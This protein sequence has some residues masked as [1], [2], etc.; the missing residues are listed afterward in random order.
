MDPLSSDPRTA[1]IAGEK[2][3]RRQ[4]TKAADRLFAELRQDEKAAWV[5]LSA[6]MS[7][8]LAVLTDRKLVA[9][10]IIADRPAQV[11]DAPFT[12]R[13]G[14]KRLMG[15]SVDVVGAQGVTVSLL[16]APPDLERIQHAAS[17]PPAAAQ[18]EPHPS[19][20]ARHAPTPPGSVGAWNWGR[21][22]A[23]WQDAEQMAADH[24]TYLG[25]SG[26]IVT[27]GTGDGGL[28]AVADGA[29]AQVK[30]HATPSG[31]PDIQRLF[32]AAAGFTNRLFYATA[33]TPAGL[34]EA[35]R[36]DIALFQFAVEGLV[37]PI[38]ARARSIA[39]TTPA[40]EE[41]G[42]FGTLTFESRQNRAVRW[43]QQIEEATTIPISNRQ[44]K[45][46]RQIAQRQQALQLMLQ[47]LDE[48]KDSDNPLY[49]ARRKERTLAQ[50]EKTLKDAGRLLGLLLR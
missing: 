44:R 18:G 40:P 11:A 15:Q 22:V 3:A 9:L 16:L 38:N 7:P 37:V 10:S 41:R 4:L 24:L 45:G 30:H 2:S 49:K 21:P 48:L 23:T 12:L 17:A 26:A 29:A 28:D 42:L 47:G 34:A 19:P 27:P 32:G 43:A 25:F 36:L 20:S 13:M 35:E 50:A 8:S 33:Y 46:A 1:A 31:S 14:K 6:G 5:A 39:P